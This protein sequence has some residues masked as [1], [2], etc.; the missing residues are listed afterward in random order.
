MPFPMPNLQFTARP[1]RR[2]L[3][4]SAWLISALALLMAGCGADP[5]K[6]DAN[7]SVDQLYE[8][9]RT[10]ATTGS[11]DRAAKLYERIEGL[12]AGTV[13][14]QQAQLEQAYLQ[15]KLGEKAQSLATIDRFLRLHPAS[16]AADY[17]YYLQGVVNFND[18]LGLFG[19]A[20]KVDLS[21]RDQQAARDAYQSFRQVVERFPQSKYAPDARVRMDYIVNS[22]AAYEV[23]VARYY[24]QRGA[25]VAAANR[26]Q[27]AVQDFRGVP[28]AEEALYLMAASYERLGLDSLRDDA[29]RVLKQSFPNGAWTAKGLPGR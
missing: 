3:G 14:A 5:K 21:E 17:A 29:M 24:Y 6:I 9:A 13:M 18:D 4:A 27:Q 2:R 26:A 8:E 10:E 1:A 23:H 25:Y 20:A 11:Y 7:K 15:L 16:P 19:G 22:L 12:G 28:A